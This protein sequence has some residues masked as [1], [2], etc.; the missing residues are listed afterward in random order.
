MK[1]LLLKKIAKAEKNNQH[2]LAQV[3]TDKLRQHN[4]CECCDKVHLNFKAKRAL[5]EAE[6]RVNLTKLNEAFNK[7]ETTLKNESLG[8]LNEEVD[9]LVVQVEKEVRKG[10]LPAILGLSFLAL[11]ELKKVVKTS[12]QD[13]LNQGMISASSELKVPLP[14]IPNP[15]RGEIN[16]R[17]ELD[18]ELVVNNMRQE[19]R[20][21]TV[22]AM[23]AGATAGAIAVALKGRLTQRADQY[24]SNLAGGVVGQYI[25]EGR[26]VVYGANELKILA[27][28][29]SEVLD[30]VTCPMCEELDGRIVIA[31]DPM[32]KL[33]QVHNHCFVA[34][35]QVL[36]NKG[37][38]NIEDVKID[39][40]VATHLDNWRPVYHNIQSKFIGELVVIELEDGTIIECTPNHKIWVNNE[41]VE[42]KDLKIDDELEATNLN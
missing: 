32:A 2:R 24:S 33:G 17:S 18:A 7:N 21:F 36:T 20:S 25:N 6:K 3:L 12:M 41:W 38:K 4:R 39:D 22:N 29:R 8:I 15:V 30:D 26:S 16:V 5:T 37:Y 9:R 28:Q 1:Q 34:G 42:A 19:A 35:T 23:I 11:G 10:S 13:S 40:V 27:Y 31:D 14:R